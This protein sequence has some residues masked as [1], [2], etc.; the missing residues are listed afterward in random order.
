M[1]DGPS[2]PALADFRHVTRQARHLAAPLVRVALDCHHFSGGLAGLL[3]EGKMRVTQFI[4]ATW[5]ALACGLAPAHAE[6]RVDDTNT[7]APMPMV[8]AQ[9]GSIGGTIGKQDK[10]AAGDNEPPTRR[11]S[12]SNGG[13]VSD[14][15]GVS[16][17]GRW[18]WSADCQSGHYTGEF[19][20]NTTSQGEFSGT[21]YDAAGGTITNG[22]VHGA[23][24]SFTRH[25][26][27][28]LTQIWKGRLTSSGHIE[29]SLSGNESCSWEA[30]K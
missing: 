26:A 4:A 11:H 10:S 7:R 27:L 16:V 12:R 6:K 2:P 30:S 3:H 8:L 23:N 9:A 21:L 19:V 1:F 17:A 25:F 29:G 20:L 24:I 15:S 18:R 5:L 28:V 22:H 14:A 13:K